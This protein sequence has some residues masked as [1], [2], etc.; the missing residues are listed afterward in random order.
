[1]LIPT[2]L[3]VAVRNSRIY[4][5]GSSVELDEDDRGPMCAD[6]Y[7]LYYTNQLYFCRG[8]DFDHLRTSLVVDHS[9]DER[10]VY[11]AKKRL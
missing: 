4:V 3:S 7:C 10:G 11:G 2:L 8:R 5:L 1:M 9:Q 6:F